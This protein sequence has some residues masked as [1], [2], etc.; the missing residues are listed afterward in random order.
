MPEP[1]VQP[2]A[3]A[4]F[5]TELTNHQG[6]LWAF[7]CSLMPGH[8]D[9]ADVLQKTNIVLWNKQD[10]FTP[11]THF[12]AWAFRIA[13]YEMLNHLRSRRRDGWVP[14]DDGLADTIAEELPQAL[15][16]SHERLAALEKC[17]ERL[18]DQDRRLL[19]HRYRR[20]SNLE[21]FS[22]SCG[23]SVSALSVTLF[24]L[25]AALRRCVEDRLLPK[26]GGA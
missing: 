22:R 18:R 8:P 13:R 2:G 12:R 26:G 4:A 24:R 15:A 20:G 6:D 21:D 11:G 25:R 10:Q 7:L 16:P 19:E 9:V 1:A 5:V 3:N 14:F 23:R 17:L